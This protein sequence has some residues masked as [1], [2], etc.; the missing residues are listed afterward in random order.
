[1]DEFELIHRY[2]STQPVQRGDVLLGV[3]DDAAL[4]HV[5]AAQ[6]LVVSTDT[7]VAGV[8]FPVGL[9]AEAVGHR[10]LAVNLSDLAAMGAAPAWVLLALTLPE[11]NEKWLEGFARG[12]F[13]LARRF[14][15]ALVG[16]NLARGALNITLS[17]HG[18][19]PADEVLTRSGAHAGDHVFVTGYMGDAAAG[20]ER[21]RAGADAADAGSGVQRFSFPEPRITAGLALRGIASA[22]IDVSDGFTADLDHI[23][24]ASGVG[25]RIAVA[26]LP[27]SPALLRHMP[28]DEAERLALS[29]GDD[30]E[31]CFTVPPERMQLFES[32]KCM[33]DCRV[34]RLGEIIP[35]KTLRCLREDGAEQPLNAAGYKHF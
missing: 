22:A 14:N 3:G 16:G 25:A 11:I 30:Y 28:R 2:F 7:L 33:L 27:L 4:L 21:L 10:A 8:H 13:Q 34:T 24:Q 15:V 26:S 6:E 31:L 18:F 35:E 5:P 20:L 17:V 1:M 19:A 12:F 32:R 9:S 29:G 23:L